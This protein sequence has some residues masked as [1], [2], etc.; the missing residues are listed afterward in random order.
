MIKRLRLFVYLFSGML[1]FHACSSANNKPIS[2]GFSADSTAILIKNIDPAGLHQI[3]TMAGPDSLKDVLVTVMDTPGDD[4]STSMEQRVP[5]HVH[6][7]QEGLEFRPA[8]PF[9]KGREYLV[10]SYLN[11]KFGNI[12]NA[13]D[14]TMHNAVKPNQQLLKR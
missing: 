8:T 3:R 14:G 11:V 6:L 1:I 5:G 7:V 9:K 2:I 10:I 4:D 12:L 13:V